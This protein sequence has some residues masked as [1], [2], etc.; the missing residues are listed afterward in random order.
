MGDIPETQSEN[1]V[2]D[3][4]QFSEMCDVFGCDTEEQLFLTAG[5]VI[6]GPGQDDYTVTEY[7]PL[8]L[9]WAIA[10]EEYSES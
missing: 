2:V 5:V 4:L 6:T 7:Q 1:I 9:T 8:G 10:N 3:P